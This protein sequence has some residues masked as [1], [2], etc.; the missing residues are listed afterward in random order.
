MPQT[1][2]EI[3]KRYWQ[4]HKVRLYDKHKKWLQENPA[5][6][7]SYNLKKLHG[8]DLETYEIMFMEQAQV[9][10]ICGQEREENLHVDHDHKTGL[11]RGLLCTDCNK[12][13]GM[14]Q[15]NPDWL[16]AAS[17]YLTT[18]QIV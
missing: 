2:S 18:N 16:S 3:N 17:K 5:K 10:A 14:F 1:K 7:R 13:L 4:K 9:C 11:I 12:G 8:I 15:D 6:Q